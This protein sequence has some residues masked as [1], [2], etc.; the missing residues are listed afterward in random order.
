MQN[1]RLYGLLLI[2]LVCV[3]C[4]EPEKPDMACPV[5]AVNGTDHN[6]VGKWALVKEHNLFTSESAKLTDHSCNNT[7][8]HFRED[9]ILI[10]SSDREKQRDILFQEY[11]YE[12]KLQ[13]AYEGFE[14]GYTVKIEQLKYGC[15]I[16][17]DRMTLDSSPLDG[18]ILYFVR[19]Q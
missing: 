5:A 6:V 1:T 15:G 17:E 9:G 7:V 4:S 3:H 11:A 13:A 19:V 2:M 14:L 16:S 8:Y 10:I 12:F 18:P